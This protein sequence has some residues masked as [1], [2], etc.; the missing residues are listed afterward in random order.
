MGTH[1]VF[2]NLKGGSFQIDLSKFKN[3]LIGAF[4]FFDLDP[5]KKFS[6]FRS[7]NWWLSLKLQRFQ[8]FV[9]C[10]S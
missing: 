7:Y 6:G 5:V 9:P 1:T 8:L 10:L 4:V 2:C 3:K